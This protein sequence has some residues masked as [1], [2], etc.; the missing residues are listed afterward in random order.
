[1]P[2]PINV[3][4]REKGR[5]AIGALRGFAYQIYQTVSA[6]HDLKNDQQLFIEVSEDFAI[7][8]AASLNAVQVKD[9]QGSI[10][11]ATEEA[12]KTLNAFWRLKNANRDRQCRVI[13]LTTGSSCK[14]RD[15]E[16]PNNLSGIEYWCDCADQSS[17][18]EPIRQVLLSLSL[19]ADLKQFIANSDS[20]E[21]FTQLIGCI[22]WSCNNPNINDLVNGIEAKLIYLGDRFSITPTEGKSI[23]PALALA[24]LEKAILSDSN[25]RILTKADFL[26]LFESCSMASVP[27]S[28]VRSLIEKRGNETLEFESLDPS[29]SN[30]E[31]IDENLRSTDLFPRTALVKHAISLLSERRSIWIFGPIGI[32]KSSLADSVARSSGKRFIRVNHRSGGSALADRISK[33][34][35][36]MAS[37]EIG[38]AIIDELPKLEIRDVVIQIKALCH[39]ARL[40]GQLVIITSN[41]TMPSALASSVGTEYPVPLLSEDEIADSISRFGGDAS[42]WSKILYWTSSAGNPALASARILGLQSRGWPKGERLEGLEPGKNIGDI[43]EERSRFRASFCRDFPHQCAQLVG[44][45]SVVGGYFDRDM[46]NA[47]VSQDCI[48]YFDMLI[49]PVIE[50]RHSGYFILTSIAGGNPKDW[51]ILD[52]TANVIRIE[53]IRSIL[54]RKQIKFEYLQTLLLHSLA[55]NDRV[56]LTAVSHIA[57]TVPNKYRRDVLGEFSLLA[58]L[59]TDP[60]KELCPGD[61]HLSALLRLAQYKVASSIESKNLNAIAARL[62]LE[63][64]RASIDGIQALSAIATT[65]M[66]FDKN[67]YLRPEEWVRLSVS[68]RADYEAIGASEHFSGIKFKQEGYQAD[69]IAFI[70][71]AGML[72]GSSDLLGFVTSLSGM[73]E[74]DRN[75]YLHSLELL[76]VQGHRVVFQSGWFRDAEV[77]P[78]P[79][80]EVLGNYKRIIEIVSCWN[81]PDIEI[82]CHNAIAVIHSEY[83]NNAEAG[84]AYIQSLR[85]EFNSDKFLK[86]QIARILFRE[87]KF[88]KAITIYES[89]YGLLNPIDWVERGFAL[90]EWA[91]SLAE[92]CDVTKAEELVSREIVSIK[93]IPNAAPHFICGLYLELAHLRFVIKKYRESTEALYAAAVSF[94]DFSTPHSFEELYRIRIFVN[95]AFPLHDPVGNQDRIPFG[96]ASNPDPTKKILDLPPV[97]ILTHWYLLAALE[98]KY[99]VKLN[100]L[101]RVESL[102]SESVLP[103]MEAMVSGDY[104]EHAVVRGDIRAWCKFAMRHLHSVVYISGNR[105]AISATV[106]NDPRR[107]FVARA[108]YISYFELNHLGFFDYFRDSFIA[109]CVGVICTQE[110]PRDIS[111][112]EE[113]IDNL[114]R[115]K[116]WL[117]KCVE[118]LLGTSDDHER[119]SFNLIIS[120]VGIAIRAQTFEAN[121]LFKVHCYLAHWVS[122]SVLSNVAI[123]LLDQW[124]INNWRTCI[125]TQRFLFNLPG[126]IAADFECI[127]SG[128]GSDRSRIFKLALLFDG[129][130][131]TTMATPMRQYFTAIVK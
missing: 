37:G 23:L 38:G 25:A 127:V 33:M 95:I 49:G 89:V 73:N 70:S 54:N 77:K 3:E 112:F 118:I 66:L 59:G 32:G 51:G 105:T 39:H 5:Q 74:E 79:A 122:K 53:I 17:D 108:K 103:I 72:Q 123:P 44:C 15:F 129:R 56:G 84:I 106:G 42:I 16:F 18:V 46:V 131:K 55:T 80:M 87:R 76:G 97:G 61:P 126:N 107:M 57:I 31:Q 100:C 94:K 92:S 27:M 113:N 96:A 85:S 19:D 63:T 69:E 114:G 1:M 47:V 67:L 99:Q 64:R 78:F 104:I 110:S 125:A 14:E 13:Y 50:R 68:L 111:L 130:L 71:R 65:T 124:L 28:V 98:E 43:D 90:R 119:D 10:S 109:I 20:N 101:E 36:S 22:T 83:C 128:P 40:N 26:K 75:R 45:L 58:H 82:E 34:I 6:W 62:L 121:E 48:P 12:A 120:E 7:A 24:V 2:S 115:I 11:L 60:D 41:D 116:P 35:A 81:R 88:D 86:R 21:L 52:E 29:P 4:T 93:S 91:V 102:S 9:V 117:K 8:S 30:D